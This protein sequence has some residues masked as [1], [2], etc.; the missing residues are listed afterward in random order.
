MD[1]IL[2]VPQWSM[3]VTVPFF[4][5]SIFNLVYFFETISNYFVCIKQE[6][7]KIDATMTKIGWFCGLIVHMI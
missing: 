7:I 1:Q 5:F 2:G 4:R 6:I 3:L